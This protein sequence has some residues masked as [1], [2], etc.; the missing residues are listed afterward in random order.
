MVC[1]AV[2]VGV[3]PRLLLLSNFAP[4]NLSL[5]PHNSVNHVFLHKNHIA[6]FRGR[7]QKSP[8]KQIRLPTLKMMKS[9]CLFA[10][11]IV[12][13]HAACGPEGCDSEKVRTPG[14]PSPK[15][16]RA[17]QRCGAGKSTARRAS[18]RRS[19]AAAPSVVFVC[20]GGGRGG[21]G[22]CAST[23]S[24]VIV[25]T[26]RARGNARARAPWECCCC[27]RGVRLQQKK[28][29][30][31]TQEHRSRKEHPRRVALLHNDCGTEGARAERAN[32]RLLHPRLPPSRRAADPLTR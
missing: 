21:G 1:F 25:R 29:G 14:G 15:N 4:R 11:V 26:S 31:G 7:K 2:C 24:C 23:A 22:G 17:A 12:A 3:K 28:R 30:T 13:A 8:Q 27:A 6:K 9:M 32:T 20:R 19:A 16:G 10:L 18:R 5:R